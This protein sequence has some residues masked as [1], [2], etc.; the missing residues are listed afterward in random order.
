MGF[1]IR[2]H[3]GDPFQ[4]SNYSV[5]LY[6]RT[7]AKTWIRNFDAFRR[8]FGRATIDH[9]QCIIKVVP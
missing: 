5:P 8:A 3:C 7:S 6:N 1:G 9:M 4:S 2:N